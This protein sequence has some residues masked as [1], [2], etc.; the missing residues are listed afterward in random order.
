MNECNHCEK[1][2]YGAVTLPGTSEFTLERNRICVLIGESPSA[3]TIFLAH[4]RIHTGEKPYECNHCGET[5]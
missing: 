5:F 2:L 1:V 4:K 3:V